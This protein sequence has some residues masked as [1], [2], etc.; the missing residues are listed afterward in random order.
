MF[1]GA[2]LMY[3]VEGTTQPESFGSVPRALWWS[4]A[5]L[6]TVGYGDVYPLTSLG[7]ILAAIMALIGIA[8][9][10]MP[11]G[12]LAAAFMNQKTNL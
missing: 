11:A 5:T 9:V 7:K 8:A 6:T 4:I 3:V 2:V 12:I 10:A 1:I